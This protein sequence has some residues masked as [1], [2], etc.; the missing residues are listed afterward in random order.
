M[1]AADACA[2]LVAGDLAAWGAALT[3]ATEAQRALHPELVSADADDLISAARSVG[4]L[5]WKVN[6]AAGAG[7][8][9]SVLCPSAAARD[10]LD[11][12]AR[13]LGQLPL[14]LR[15]AERGAHV[16]AD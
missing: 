4:A 12:E 10:R 7:G 14:P 11:E 2:A 16:A 5:G 1:L 8:S 6:G 9:L 15:L 13:R 3:W